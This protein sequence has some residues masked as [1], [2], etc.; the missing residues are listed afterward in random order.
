MH[1]HHL[2]AGIG[3]A[4][5]LAVGAA[6][7]A[8]RPSL[9]SLRFELDRTQ[10]L[11]LAQAQRAA[12]PEYFRRAYARYPNL[13]A[14]ALE[15]IAYAETGWNHVRPDA[16]QD[17]HELHMPRSYGVM[18]LYHGGGFADQVGD[19]ARL[20]GRT[21]R[22]VIDDPQS[23]ILAAAALLDRAL[24]AGQGGAR[25][26]ALA[27]SEDLA[28][29]LAR[30]AGY[31][32]SDHG[33]AAY[34]RQSF[35]YGVLDTLQRGVDAQGVRIAPQ[36]LRLERAFAPEQ[37]RKLRAPALRIDAGDGSVRV[38][39]AF[40]RELS[41]EVRAAPS[42]DV[43]VKAVDFGEAIWNPASSSNYSTAG[44]AMSA[45]ILH[46]MEGS[47]AGSIA[48]FQNPSAQVS[49]HYLI[50]KSDGQI[51]QMVREHHQAWHAKYHN[52]YTVGIEHDGRAADAANWSSAM[53]NASA[54]LTKSL[55]AR[56]GIDCRTAWNGPGY[57]TWH[58]V[59]DSVRIK[60]H[61]ML[62]Q[63]QN[64][65]DPGKYFPWTSYYTLLNGGGGT[66]TPGKYWVDTFADAT[67]YKW[68]STLTPLGTLYKGT[69]Y[70]YCKA[71]GQEVRVGDSY[72]HY[73]LKTDLDVG[74]AGA[75]VSA[76]Y[77]SRWGNDEA[78]DNSGAVIPDC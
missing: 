33:L 18:G 36:P 41:Q 48:W 11:V 62:S 6:G 55:C 32:A 64:R 56:R 52:N 60:G 42:G 73:W 54:R 10:A 58:L 38:D 53:L 26:R 29:A 71:W 20:I 9:D 35:A 17:A 16:A 70:V 51:T 8:Q 66:P 63:N 12:Y 19:G 49:A 75:W 1:L 39:E 50:R 27:R 44:N 37:L 78:R 61:G 25:S 40:A 4:L 5:C 43:S 15:A 22:Q 57:D 30:Y 7:A 76:Y 65:Y 59:P 68:P 47:Y 3:G 31:G 45:V 34:A 2:A 46:T 67:G 72:N 77:L 14:G 24:A 74:P 21:A 23:N 69:N 28:P 13:P